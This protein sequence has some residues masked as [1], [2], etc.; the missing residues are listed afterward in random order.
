MG[1][2]RLLLDTCTFIWLCAEP[3]R[4][5]KKASGDL[6]SPE[7]ELMLSDV[8]AM[9]ISLKWSA[10]KIDL[11]TT[12][13]QWIES[14]IRSWVLKELPLTREIIYRSTELPPH[15]RDPFDRF[16]VATAIVNDAILVTPDSEIHRYP[17]GWRW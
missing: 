7:S 15:H 11:P 1:P 14:Q 2:L 4:L 3:G 6:D 10:G 5:S 16:L 12:P 13:R 17:V 9:E 8:T